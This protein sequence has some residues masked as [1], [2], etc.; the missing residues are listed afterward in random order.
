MTTKTLDKNEILRLNGLL[1]ETLQQADKEQLIACVRLLGTSVASLKIKYHADDEAMP[2]VL[3]QFVDELENDS[4]SDE[5]AEVMAKSI[6]EC[7]TAIAV[8][9][10]AAQ[11]GKS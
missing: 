9:K 3:K 10:K 8:A 11:Q 5:L 2:H 1:D 7:A 6:I 4:I